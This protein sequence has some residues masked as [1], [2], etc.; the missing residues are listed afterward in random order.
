MS[1]NDYRAGARQVSFVVDAGLLGAAKGCAADAGLS[2]S[3][4]LRGVVQQAVESGSTGRPLI[5]VLAGDAEAPRVDWESIL[6][7]GLGKRQVDVVPVVDEW[8]ESV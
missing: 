1:G 7:R 6:G 5:D 4:W 8:L 2:L 3:G